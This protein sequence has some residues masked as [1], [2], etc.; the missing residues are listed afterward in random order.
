MLR[1]EAERLEQKAVEG[2]RAAGTS[3]SKIGALYG[4]TKQGAQQRFRQ[5]RT[6]AGPAGTADLP[7]AEHDAG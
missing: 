2:V 5:D 3:W 6:G 1:E 4:L 7:D